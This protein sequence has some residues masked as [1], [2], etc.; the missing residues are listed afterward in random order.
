MYPFRFDLSKIC[1]TLTMVTLAALSA[2]GPRAVHAA[3]LSAISC[4]VGT[5]TVQYTPGVTNTLTPQDIRVHNTFESCIDFSNGGIV[6]GSMDFSS[7]GVPHSCQGTVN[8]A[9]NISFTIN[10]SN[11]QGLP[12]G[13]SDVTAQRSITDSGTLEV[14]GLV[15]SVTRGLFV[16]QRFAETIEF[17][18]IQNLLLCNIPPGVQQRTSI[19]NFTQIGLL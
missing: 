1:A 7:S 9:D 10:W 18:S 13:S 11:A 8:H 16:R 2:A 3:G 4:P 5:S 15:G 17:V 6:R 12:V 19:S 14:V